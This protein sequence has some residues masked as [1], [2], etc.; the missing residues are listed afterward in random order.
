MLT[1]TKDDIFKD[2]KVIFW[3]ALNSNKLH[4]ALR[5]V[6]LQARFLGMFEK[7][8]LPEAKHFSD[9]AEEQLRDFI[10]VLEENDPTLKDQEADFEDYLQKKEAK[11]EAPKETQENHAHPEGKDQ[12]AASAEGLPKRE[13]G[14]GPGRGARLWDGFQLVDY[15]QDQEAGSAEGLPKRET[16]GRD[17]APPEWEHPPP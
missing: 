10:A 17:G 12:E 16:R 2:L 6:E 8:H 5:V 1:M 13:P 3:R 7:Q 9:M 15:W 4:I 11:K 14:K